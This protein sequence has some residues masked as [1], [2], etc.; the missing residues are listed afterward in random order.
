MAVCWGVGGVVAVC[1][2]WG[3]HHHCF[4][5][6]VVEA[7]PDEITIGRL[8]VYGYEPLALRPYLS[9]RY[10]KL[11]QDIQSKSGRVSTHHLNNG[12]SFFIL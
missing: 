7:L 6:G 12:P 10:L 3:G 2:G 1:V 8:L 5:V 9:S 4:G 11:K